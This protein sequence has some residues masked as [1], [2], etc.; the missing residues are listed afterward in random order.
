MRSPTLASRPDSLVCPLCERRKLY[1]SDRDSMRCES[2]GGRLSG[3]MLTTLRRIS[4]LP[5]A[6]GRHACECGRPEMRLLPDGVFHCPACS[7]EVLPVDA[8]TSLSKEPTERGM[9]YWAGWVDGRFGGSGSFTDNP[10][11]ARWESPSDRLDY[12]RG[13]RAGS[14]ACRARRLGRKG[15]VIEEGGAL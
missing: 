1:P 2:C 5:D 11:L 14:E 10:H 9:A 15:H 13:H 6:I 3:A 12:Y 4:A 7:S 8:P